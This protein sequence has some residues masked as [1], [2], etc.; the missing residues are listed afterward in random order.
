MKNKL[1]FIIKLLVSAGLIIFILYRVNFKEVAAALTSM[2][3]LWYGTALFTWGLFFVFVVW[4]WKIIL[5]Y[6][7]FSVPYLYLMRLYLTGIFFN[8]FLPSTIGGDGYRI[9]KLIKYS[10]TNYQSALSVLIDRL[11]G[12]FALLILALIFALVKYKTIEP[13]ILYLVCGINL[14]FWI[15]IYILKHE[16]M[17]TLLM[18]ILKKF[19]LTKISELVHE[20]YDA[21]NKYKT[22]YYIPVLGFSFLAQL[23]NISV[24]YF[25]GTALGADISI[26]NYVLYFPLIAILATIPITVNGLGLRENLYVSFFMRTGMRKEVAFA[27]SVGYYILTVISSIA[28][29]IWYMFAGEEKLNE[30]KDKI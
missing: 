10:K 28:G 2:S 20:I 21:L 1:S 15:G 17:Y 3:L 4:K 18:K 27:L 30:I 6:Q 11:S 14:V 8:N 29:G 24:N 19:N 26:I 25:I 23:T 16:K 22:K 7:G 5:K 9:Y 12:F 13:M